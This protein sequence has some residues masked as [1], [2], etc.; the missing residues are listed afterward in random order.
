MVFIILNVH[1]AT[2]SVF[3]FLLIFWQPEPFFRLQSSFWRENHELYFSDAPS[4]GM[5]FLPC[6]SPPFPL[7]FSF[8][9]KKPGRISYLLKNIG[10]HYIHTL[11]RS[12]VNDASFP[13]TRFDRHFIWP[14]RVTGPC[15]RRRPAGRGNLCDFIPPG[16][17][18]SEKRFSVIR[19]IVLL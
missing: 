2:P 12:Q 11:R 13:E 3:F 15:M 18:T 14:D 1:A 9:N 4:A 8:Y 19:K 5:S 17:R 16:R 6:S 7:I 10:L